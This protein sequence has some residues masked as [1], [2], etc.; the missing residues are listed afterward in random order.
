[1]RPASAR[2]EICRRLAERYADL[3]EQAAHPAFRAGFRQLA[4]SYNAIASHIEAAVQ[5][6]VSEPKDDGT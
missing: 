3:A 6:A 5:A 4:A 2:A 1:M